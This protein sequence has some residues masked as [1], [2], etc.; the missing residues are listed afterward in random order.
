MILPISFRIWCFSLS[1]WRIAQK[2]VIKV[3]G[4]KIILYVMI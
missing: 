4:A 2:K 3:K 1:K